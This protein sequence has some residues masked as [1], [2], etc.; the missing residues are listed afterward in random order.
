MPPSDV[1]TQVIERDGRLEYPS[2]EIRVMEGADKGLHCLVAPDGVRIGTAAGNA[3]QLTDRTVSRMHCE[4][5][6]ASESLRLVD[7]DSTNGTYVNDVRVFSAELRA[8]AVVR[9]GETILGVTTASRTRSSVELSPRHR[10]A[11]VIGASTEMR[12]LFD[13]LEKVSPTEASVL[14]QGET[15]TGKE[16]VARAIHDASPRANG[17]F[18]VVDCGA[19][20]ENLIESE[21][22]GHV[23]GAFSG[24]VGERRGLFEEA[25]RGTIF[26]DE[27]GELPPS[28]QPRLLRVLESH[29]VRRVGS[30]SSKKIDVRIVAATNRSLAKSVNEGNFREDLYYRLAVVELRLPPLRARR[31][32]IALLAEHFCRRYAGDKATLPQE[33][34][35]TLMSRD[36]PGN[37]REL[38]NFIERSVSLGFSSPNLSPP[39]PRAGTALPTGFEEVV[40]THLPLKDARAAWTEQFELFYVKALLAKTN[41]NVTRA[42]ELAGINR[43]SLQ[44]LIASLGIRDESSGPASDPKA[45][46]GDG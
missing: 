2:I 20:A 24:A 43:R 3:L 38:R 25:H 37:V 1:T 18:V 19:I 42:A 6:L 40:P 7:S 23:R 35:A 44:R 22:F 45:S 41:N 16:L 14:I 27:I 4:V 21:L 15:G 9:V 33:F 26:L 36:W 31:Q 30:N 34:L 39:S 28:L 11:E 8:G 10:F 12:R 46:E 17:P 13:V 32:D 5:R 29:E